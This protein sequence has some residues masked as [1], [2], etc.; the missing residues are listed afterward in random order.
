MKASLTRR[1]VLGGLGGAAL[2]LGARGAR[3]APTT[4]DGA[5]IL[6]LA[7]DIAKANRGPLDPKF[8]GVFKFHEIAFDSAFCFDRAMLGALP[9]ETFEARLPEGHE[10]ASFSGPRLAAVLQMA[11]APER[12]SISATAL[13]GYVS[14][15]SAAEIAGG[16]WVLVLARNAA[17]L[18]IGGFG[19]TMLLAKPSGI[20]VGEDA[21]WPWAVF[22]IQVTK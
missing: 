17:P 6:T 2:A 16:D 10:K 20:D 7:G 15:L 19:P 3:S 11:G 4:P 14:E 8:D 22:Y 13:D 9:Q 21:Q 1:T 12:P 18:G 5:V